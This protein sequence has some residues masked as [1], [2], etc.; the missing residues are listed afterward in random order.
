MLIHL[1]QDYDNP[2]QFPEPTA[3]DEYIIPKLGLGNG[4]FFF[5]NIATFLSYVT[6]QDLPV[7]TFSVG[8]R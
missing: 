5:S 6:P 2:Q 3:T 4:Y 8:A 1:F 7:G